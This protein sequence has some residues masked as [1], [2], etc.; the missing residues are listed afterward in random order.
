MNATHSTI[1]WHEV[2]QRI[3]RNQALVGEAERTDR[4]KLARVFHERAARLANRSRAGST[5][6]A[7]V[8]MLV[9]QLGGERFGIALAHLEQVFPQSPITPVPGAADYLLGVANLQGIV[10]S[11]VDPRRLMHLPSDATDKG[12]LVLVRLRDCFVALW[13]EQLEGVAQIDMEALA[14]VDHAAAGETPSFVKGVTDDH[15]MV[16]DL[17]SLLEHVRG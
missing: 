8:P 4:S 10:R 17:A 1:D 12:Y 13:V 2:K 14:P 15:I 5:G 9:I 7:K 6:A 16:L 3:A 11:V